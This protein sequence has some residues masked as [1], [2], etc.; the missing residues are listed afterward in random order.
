MK[1]FNSKQ[2]KYIMYMFS[3]IFLCELLLNI[4]SMFFKAV[5]I[6]I[7]PFIIAFCLLVLKNDKE[8]K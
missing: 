2:K 6:L 7:L 8:T 5:G 1:I 3:L 4:D